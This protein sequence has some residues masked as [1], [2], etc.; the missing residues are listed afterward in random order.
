MGVGACARDPHGLVPRRRGGPGA[1][2][3]PVWRCRSG[4]AP[5]RLGPRS[6]G[7]VPI[8]YNSL[9]TGRPREDPIGLGTAK[10]DPYY[11]TGYIDESTNR[12][13]PSA[14]ASLYDVQLFPDRA[15]AQS[16]GARAVNE[17]GARLSVAAD[18]RNTGAREGTETVQLYIGC[19]GRASPGR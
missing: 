11:V 10:A 16:I 12:C 14:A 9:N 13:I 19:A 3:E 1:R 4:G 2:R 17:Q 18:I 7:Q 6:V 5:H 8:Y 15:S